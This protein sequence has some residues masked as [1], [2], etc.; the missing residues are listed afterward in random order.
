MGDAAGELPDRLHLLGLPQRVFRLSAIS[1]FLLDALLERRIEAPQLVFGPAALDRDAE[2]IC[3]ALQE[4]DIVLGKRAGAF[5]VRFKH[6]IR[7]ALAQQDHIGGA[8][9]AMFSQQSWG[10][11]ALLSREHVGD[12]GLSGVQRVARRRVEIGSKGGVPHHPVMPSDAGA[13]QKPV[14]IRQELKNLAEADI[15][16]QRR[17][18]ACIIEKGLEP[19]IGQSAAPDFGEQGLLSEPG[20]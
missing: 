16:A 11:E 18:P 4:V 10:A 1:D 17:Q 3:D 13:H 19:E 8:L 15:Q 5:A 9:D 14:L 7:A 12:D 6:S 2:Q 20:G